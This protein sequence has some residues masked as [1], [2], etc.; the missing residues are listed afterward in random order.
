MAQWRLETLPN[1]L[2]WVDY[3]NQGGYMHSQLTNYL[4]NDTE[5]QKIREQRNIA[6]ELI[7]LK[8]QGTIKAGMTLEQ[9]IE[10]LSHIGE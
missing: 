1:L 8:S 10:K 7:L 6:C 4:L 5:K 3:F 9:I 2:S